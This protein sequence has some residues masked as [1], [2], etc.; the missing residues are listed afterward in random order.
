MG[1]NSEPNLTGKCLECGGPTLLLVKSRGEYRATCSVSCGAKLGQ[2]KVLAN[3]KIHPS[4]TEEVKEKRKQTCLIKY[5]HTTA[6]KQLTAKTNRELAMASSETKNKIKNTL[7]R[8]YGVTS[9]LKNEAILQKMKDTNLYKFGAAS[10]MQNINV[11][12]NNIKSNRDLY[13]QKGLQDKLNKIRN[14]LDIIPEFAEDQYDGTD[15]EYPW[16]HLTCKLEFSSVL[17]VNGALPRCPKCHPKSISL[18]QSLVNDFIKSLGIECLSNDR[19][20]IR[21]LELD[22]YLPSE[23]LAIE[24]N[25]V[26]WHQAGERTPLLLKTELC[27]SL[28]IKLLHFWDYEILN[29][30]EVVKSIIRS[31]LGIIST[32]IGARKCQLVKISKTEAAHF[33]NHNHLEA[34]TAISSLNL[35]LK[36]NEEILAVGTFGKSRFKKGEIELLRFCTK[37]NVSCPGAI[38]RLVKFAKVHFGVEHIVTFANRR[39]A[40]FGSN[41]SAVGTYLYKTP[42]N[43]FYITGF[44]RKTLPRLAVQKHKLKNLI[45]DFDENL[46]AE[47]NIRRAG[48]IKISD[49]GNYKLLL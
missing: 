28:G 19:K 33:L 7:I 36:L 9:P 5:G 41:Y 8:R 4:Q 20:I 30:F 2:K 22:I 11:K 44:G 3:N 27:E 40:S 34:S 49:S 17:P 31:K 45:D 15:K 35:A 32:K 48:W 13:I 39:Y 6:L 1:K 47:E 14:L 21:P 12:T 23:K 18:P 43:Y 25:G 38:S 10:A 29:S 37:N 16:R 24:V 42:P 26:Y 46:T